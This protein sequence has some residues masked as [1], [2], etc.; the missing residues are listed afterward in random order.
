MADA[1]PLQY[2]QSLLRLAPMSE[3]GTGEP[4]PVNYT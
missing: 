1:A 4:R 3:E 2:A